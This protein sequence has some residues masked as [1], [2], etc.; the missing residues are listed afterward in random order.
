[1]GSQ[2]PEI[3]NFRLHNVDLHPD[4]GHIESL[5]VL[6]DL[7]YE[8][9]F[10]LSIDADMVLGKKGF[11]SVKGLL[12]FLRMMVGLGAIRVDLSEG[13]A[14]GARATE[15]AVIHI[16]IMFLEARLD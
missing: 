8:G 1:M 6:L 4:E 3:K 11:L 9:N 10:R 14:H 16:V 15:W 7:H 12:N 2:F 5:D 13:K